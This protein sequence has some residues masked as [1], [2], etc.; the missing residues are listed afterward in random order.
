MEGREAEEEEEKKIVEGREFKG[1]VLR[2]VNTLILLHFF[3]KFPY[4]NTF[5]LHT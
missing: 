1:N 3:I 2:D 5:Y 4:S